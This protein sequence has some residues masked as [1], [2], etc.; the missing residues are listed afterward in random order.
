MLTAK[1]DEIDRVV[2]LEMGADERGTSLARF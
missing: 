2:G 1:S